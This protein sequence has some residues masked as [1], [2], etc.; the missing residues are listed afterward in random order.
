MPTRRKLVSLAKVDFTIEYITDLLQTIDKVLLIVYHRETIQKLKEAFKDSV[1]LQGGMTSDQKHQNLIEFQ[2]NENCKLLIGQ[3]SVTG[4]GIDG[5]Q[6]VCNYIV[7]GEI[8]WSP[9]ILEQAKDRLRRIG[10]TKTVFV[11]YLIASNTIEEE[12][13]LKLEWKRNIISK[14]IRPVHVERKQTMN[15]AVETL[16]L[17]FAEKVAEAVAQKLA[18]K[19]KGKEPKTVAVPAETVSVQPGA[20]TVTASE[21]QTIGPINTGIDRSELTVKAQTL[22]KTLKEAGVSKEEADSYYKNVLLE[23]F[24]VKKISEM[25][26]DN[27]STLNH[28]LNDHDMPSALAFLLPSNNI[29]DSDEV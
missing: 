10:Q 22:L 13:D 14:L 12:I 25:I 28:R 8:D 16:A 4:Y 18:A 17:F 6:N 9:G 15:Q 26:D 19:P 1:I 2:T 27:L 20:V 21:P 3:I 5:L 24:K 23:G 11:H 29:E 7:F